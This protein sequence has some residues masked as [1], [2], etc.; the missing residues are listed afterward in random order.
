MI[1]NRERQGTSLFDGVIEN[2]LKEAKELLEDLANADEADKSQAKNAAGL[3]DR[4]RRAAAKARLV[5]DVAVANRIGAISSR[6]ALTEDDLVRLNSDEKVRKLVDAIDPAH[7]PYLFPEVFLRVNPGFDVLVGN[8]PFKEAT[9]A[10]LDFWNLKFKGLRGMKSSEQ[11]AEVQRLR[12]KFPALGMEFEKMQTEMAD[13][14]R[15]LA[16]GPFPGMGVGDPDF[17][18]AFAWRSLSLC[19][20]GGAIGLVMPHSIWTTKGSSEWRKAFFGQ[21]DSEIVLVVNTKSWAFENVNPGYRFSFISARK[22]NQAPHTEIRGTF[23]SKEAFKNGVLSEV[24]RLSSQVLL[25][26]D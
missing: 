5:F 17:Y 2:S 16:T 18:K 21:T 10:E 25:D 14:R 19:R 24:P 9:V 8:P 3:A 1:P 26:A 7:F 20:E 6:T 12:D 23:D 22:V 13:L 15:A 4:A 11:I